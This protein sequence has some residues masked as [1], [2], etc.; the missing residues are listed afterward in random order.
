MLVVSVCLS[1]WV[2]ESYDRLCQVQ[3]TFVTR[4]YFK[5]ACGAPDLLYIN[6]T[7]VEHFVTKIL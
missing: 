2:C 6:I 3:A 7:Y 1:I 5:E 4:L